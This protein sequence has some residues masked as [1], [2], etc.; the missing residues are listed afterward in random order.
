MPHMSGSYSWGLGTVTAR[1]L[2]RPPRR[3][4]FTTGKS[5]RASR[6]G[7]TTAAR[8]AEMWQAEPRRRTGHILAPHAAAHISFVRFPGCDMQ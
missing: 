7:E 8:G 2:F 3:S 6:P 1:R 5:A 4:T